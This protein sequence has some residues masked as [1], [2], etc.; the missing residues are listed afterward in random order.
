MSPG[1][2]TP[3]KWRW[4]AEKLGP[5]LAI[6]IDH[7]RVEVRH[8]GTMTY[9]NAPFSCEHLLVSEATFL[10]EALNR[11]VTKHGL[12]LRWWAMTFVISPPKVPIHGIEANGIFQA[13]EMAGANAVR[14]ASEPTWC[15]NHSTW[16]DRYVDYAR[17]RR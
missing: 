3:L 11:A 15:P 1:R 6:S 12:G 9:A 14:W 2:S 13:A 8:N 17:E 5:E 16:Q 4:W 10:E 7:N